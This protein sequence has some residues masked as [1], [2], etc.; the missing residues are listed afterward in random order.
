MFALMTEIG[1]EKTTKNRPPVV[2][3]LGHVDHGKTKLLDTIRK[4]KVAEKESGGITQHIGAYQAE[5]DGKTIT[6]LDTPG[7]E[8]FSAIR[9]RGARIADIAILVVAADESVKPQTKEAI[10]II[11]SE[12][13]PVIIAINKID[14]E[15]AN[16]QKVRQ[17][18]AA[19]NILVEDWGGKVPV[20][21]ISAKEGRN[22]QELLDIILL[23]AELE[24][25]KEDISS[26]AEGI[27]IESRLDKRRGHI[28]SAIIQ[29]GVLRPGDWLVVGTI[30]GKIKSMEDFRGSVIF[31]ARPSQ[32][33]LIPGWPSAPDI[34]KPFVTAD[35]KDAALRISENNVDLAPLFSFIKESAKDSEETPG[36][37]ILNLVLK[38]DFSGSLEAVD[39]ALNTIKSEE[40]GYNVV[41]YDIGNITEADVK[42]AIHSNGQIVGFRVNTEESAQKIADKESVKISSF[43]VIYDLV[44][45][46]RKELGGLLEP[47]IERTQL[48]R[49]KVLATFK[50]DARSQI[51]GGKVMSGKITRGGIVEVFRNGTKIALGKIGQ[52]Q[53]NKADS[54]EVKE[55]QEAGIRF[56]PL[57]NQPSQEIKEGDILEVYEEK[58]IERTL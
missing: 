48:G 39:S 26:P 45:Y 41:R 2:V 52:L 7:H 58:K 3:V 53:Q 55:G 49:L 11:E 34:G 43:D 42:S 28:A 57:P 46:I 30:V 9:A 6:F 16:P 33:V 18:L 35:S 5:T 4:T 22:I 21:E 1:K 32:P 40:V 56:D 38:A 20:L 23:V 8:A 44:E 54:S 17:D 12:K 51:I 19:E 24:E 14:K 36:K 13:I 29:K 27:I 31:E 37:K 47:E 25:L 50:K 15:G 10:K